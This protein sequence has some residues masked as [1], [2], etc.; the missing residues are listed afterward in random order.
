VGI[1]L[2]YAVVVAVC[3]HSSDFFSSLT[4][5]TEA[6]SSYRGLAVFLT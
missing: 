3:S 6:R 1:T 2:V 5:P 4:S